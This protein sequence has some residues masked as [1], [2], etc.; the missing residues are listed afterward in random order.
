MARA[1]RPK[2]APA[3]PEALEA[4]IVPKRPDAPPVEAHPQEPHP[5]EFAPP[6]VENLFAPEIFA[7]EAQ[8]ISFVQGLISVAFTSTRYDYSTSPSVMK[9]VVVSRLVMSPAGAQSLAVQL[10]AFLDKK[11]LGPVRP[12]D[13]K[14][15]Q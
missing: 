8:S 9:K 15:I 6:L 12:K 2:K 13:P 3:S 14:Q 7:T 5:H 11:G 1:A 4:E 10:F